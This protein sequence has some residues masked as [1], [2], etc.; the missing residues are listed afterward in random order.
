MVRLLAGAD[1]YALYQGYINP[2]RL[3]F[4]PWYLIFVDPQ[5]G[6]RFV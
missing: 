1:Y 2:G 5:F 3:N 4:V 6:A